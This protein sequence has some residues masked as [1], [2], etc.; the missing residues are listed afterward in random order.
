MT[1][2][3][4]LVRLGKASGDAMVWINHLGETGCF[5]LLNM[6]D[7]IYSWSLM[8]VASAPRL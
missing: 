3:S 7:R 2:F 5:F 1:P 4:H 6:V 8:G